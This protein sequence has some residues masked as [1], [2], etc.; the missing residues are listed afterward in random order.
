MPPRRPRHAYPRRS[1]CGAV[2]L[3]VPR[4]AERRF[5]LGRQG[6][7]PG[8]RW[9]GKDGTR[10]AIQTCVQVQVDPLDVVGRSHDLVLASRVDGYR[11][12]Y[13]EEILYSERAAYEHGGT[14]C[15]FPRDRMALA[16]SELRYRGL[17]AWWRDWARVHRT[18]VSRVREEIRSLGPLE[19]RHWADGESTENYRS[20]RLEGVALH[21]LWRNLEI[22][23]HHRESGRKFYD[24]T[25]RMFG[26]PPL[27]FPSAATRERSAVLLAGRLGLSGRRYLTHLPGAPGA[28]RRTPTV[29]RA[30]RQRLVDRGLLAEVRIDGE[31]E[32]G[33]LRA[34]ELPELETVVAGEVPRAWKPLDPE[35]EA[36]FLGPLDLVSAR[37]RA[38][39]LF[40]FE[41]LWEVYMPAARRRWGY[42]VLPV[43]LGD[44][45]VGRIEPTRDRLHRAL[46]V[47]R[48][49]W[50]KGVDPGAIVPPLA[51]GLVRTARGLGFHSVRLGRVGP[52]AFRSA[53]ERALTARFRDDPPGAGPPVVRR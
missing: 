49:W 52:V 20:R 46:R 50:E 48:A 25:E 5:V 40:D 33:V 1:L 51:R 34:E 2:V 23:V 9:A 29:L 3:R 45:L 15:I 24:L 4:A 39:A 19:S 21:F 31:R 10:T 18:H 17:P 43:L 41:Y 22:L 27:L 37:G 53:L 28:G 16:R 47:G 42:Y 26:P 44:R 32:P 12:E 11:P 13:L 14:L 8:R 35:P 7:W 6:L 30:Y 36:V 38:E